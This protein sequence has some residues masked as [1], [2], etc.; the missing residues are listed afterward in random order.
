M[1]MADSEMA[2]RVRYKVLE[3]ALLRMYAQHAERPANLCKV[4]VRMDSGE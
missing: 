3:E 2:E 4:A 1:Y